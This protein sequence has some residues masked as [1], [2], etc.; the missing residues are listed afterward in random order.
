V[1]G[2]QPHIDRLTAP[3]S[4]SIWVQTVALQVVG[5]LRPTGVCRINDP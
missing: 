2:P 4:C 3:H 1:V 5:C